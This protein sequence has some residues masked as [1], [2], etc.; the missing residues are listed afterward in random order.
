MSRPDRGLMTESSNGIILRTRRLTETS[1][2]VN[3]LTSA[4]G[5]LSTVA[6]GAFRPR[7]PFAGKLDLFYEAD[8]T[9]GR[10]QRS[11]LHI[12]REVSVRETHGVLRR[13][14]GCLQ[15]AAYCAALIEQTTET[16]TPLPEVHALFAGLLSSVT[17]HPPKA[18]TIFAF[19]LKLLRV[20]GLEPDVAETSLAAETRSLLISLCASTWEELY[21]LRATAGQ[22]RAIQLFLHG[23]LIFHLGRIPP[24]RARALNP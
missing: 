1:L 20:L 10:S 11:E 16:E 19:E 5:R 15:Q 23:Y 22:A 14:L 8:F 9:F 7:S 21:L 3:W 18:R 17:G 13:D 24:H 6:K 2:I 4:Q 12:L